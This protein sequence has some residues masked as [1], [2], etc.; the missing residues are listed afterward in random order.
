MRSN[1]PSRRID[2]TEKKNTLF[3]LNDAD[4]DAAAGGFKV[5]INGVTKTSYEPVTL[6]RGLR[7]DGDLV[8]AVSKKP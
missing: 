7:S 2:K 6:E 8:Q 1:P 5:E 3:A 4:L